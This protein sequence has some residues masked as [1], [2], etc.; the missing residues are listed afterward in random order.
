MILKRFFKNIK[1][2][3]LTLAQKMIL[4]LILISSFILFAM[5]VQNYNAYQ[6]KKQEQKEWIK[7]YDEE[8]RL[9]FET[10]QSK[11]KK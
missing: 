4:L 8:A 7:F 10:E 1:S 9:M 2:V 11:V 6:M 5:L 3:Q